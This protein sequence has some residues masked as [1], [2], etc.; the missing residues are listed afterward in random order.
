MKGEYNVLSHGDNDTNTETGY[1]TAD[2]ENS[3][4]ARTITIPNSNINISTVERAT[5]YRYG[6]PSNVRIEIRYGKDSSVFELVEIAVDYIKTPQVIRLTQ[7]QMD[8]TEDTSQ[9]M[10]YPDYV[11]QEIINELT[12]LVMARTGDPLLNNFVPINQTIANPAQ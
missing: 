4:L 11:C 12:T 6:N 10:E 9:I 3:N 7:E 2:N 5:A 1:S 8:L